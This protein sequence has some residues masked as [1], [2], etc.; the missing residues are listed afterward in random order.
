M[1][2]CNYT[3]LLTY[4]NVIDRRTDV[5]TIAQATLLPRSVI[6]TGVVIWPWPEAL[7]WPDCTCARWRCVAAAWLRARPNV[8]SPYTTRHTPS[9]RI[10]L[11]GVS[12]THPTFLSDYS[13]QNSQAL[14]IS[15]AKNPEEFDIN[16]YIHHTWKT[17]SF[18]INTLHL[19]KCRTMFHFCLH[20]TH[21]IHRS[22]HARRQHP[23]K[24]CT[25][26]IWIL[27]QKFMQ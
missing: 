16:E 27:L 17:S 23:V 3:F 15:G 25:P 20:A 26:V 7:W 19:V 6:K 22:T 1:T 13:V 14:I 18:H 8:P 21:N 10:Q 2:S 12:K 24:N 4:I 9:L 11:H 5:H